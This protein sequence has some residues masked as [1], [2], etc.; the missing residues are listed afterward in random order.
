[1]NERDPIAAGRLVQARIE[2][3]TA[4]SQH[5]IRECAA[6][7]ASLAKVERLLAVR[8]KEIGAVAATLDTMKK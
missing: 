5:A 4:D 1:M 8:E 6:I 3:L 7:L 2:Q